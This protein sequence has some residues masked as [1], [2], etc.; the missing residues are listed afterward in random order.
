LTK[1]F[2]EKEDATIYLGAWRKYL[3]NGFS[4]GRLATS[5]LPDYSDRFS[6]GHVEANVVKGVHV[7]PLG[8]VMYREILNAE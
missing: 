7:S 4:E 2:T 6:P 5:S 1:L 8:R 3:Q